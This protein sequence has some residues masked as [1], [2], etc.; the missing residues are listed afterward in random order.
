MTG[1]QIKLIS[2]RNNELKVFLP[3]SKSNFNNSWG[4]KIEMTD[5]E[6]LG[7]YDSSQNRM[8]RRFN[9][10]RINRNKNQWIGNNFLVR[11]EF[12]QI[13][14]DSNVSCLKHMFDCKIHNQ[15]NISMMRETHCQ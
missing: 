4:E 2:I 14:G 1:R 13:E 11:N 15:N 3:F 5:A 8:N 7:V 9:P 10:N 12:P 6:I